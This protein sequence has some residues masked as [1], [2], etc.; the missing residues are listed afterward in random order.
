MDPTSIQVQTLR[1]HLLITKKVETGYKIT[2]WELTCLNYKKASLVCQLN[3]DYGLKG[4]RQVEIVRCLIT[5]SYICSPFLQL[6][7]R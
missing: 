7:S 4:R 2:K 6:L 1:K 5:G 3:I